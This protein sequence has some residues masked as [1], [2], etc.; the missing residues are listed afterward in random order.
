LVAYDGKAAIETV[1]NNEVSL[2]LLD[3]QLPDMSG[4]E[5]LRQLD[6]GGLSV[7]SILITAN[8]SEHVAAEAFRL[9]VEDYLSK[10]VEAE[11]LEEAINKA[12]NETHLRQAK[13]KLT[14]QLQEQLANK[15]V[16]ADIGKSIT[17]SLDINQVLRKIVEAAV[18]LTKAEEGFLALLDNTSGQLYLRAEKNL[19][20]E[21]S[22]TIKLP[23]SDE[24][25]SKVFN[26]GK[27]V[28]ISSPL[29][30][31]SGIKLVTGFLVQSLMHVPILSKGKPQGV[32]SV[33]NRTY[34]N[35]FNEKFE[36]LLISLAD[37]A[38]IAIENASLYHKAQQEI[39]ERKRVEETLRVS[40]ERYALAAQGASDGIWDWDL[41]NNQIY[42][43]PRW[44]AML[45][46]QDEDISQ[47]PTEW[48]SRVSK[49]DLEG[50]KLDISAHLNK[51]TSHFENE[52]RIVHKDGSTRWMLCRGLAVF[53]DE[54]LATRVAGSI[55]DITEWK[56]AE[57]KLLHDAFY[58]KLTGIPNRALFMD[59]LRL[60][61]ERAKRKDDYAYAVLFL[62]IDRFKDVN[63]IYGHLIGDKLLAEF[64][65]LLEQRMR[66]TDTVARFGGDEFVILLDD[67]TSANNATQIAEW[68]QSEL[69]TPFCLE[70]RDIYISIST[71]IVLS[72]LEYDNADDVLRDADI[73]MYDAKANG[74][75]RYEMFEPNMRIRVMDRLELE[76]DLR[77]A[78]D[79][80]E[81]D[82][83]YQMI[84]SLQTGKIVGFEALVRWNHPIRGQLPPNLFIPIA[85]ESGLIIS[86]DR[87]VMKE[88][89]L[90]IK[91]WQLESPSFKDLA[92]SV[93]LSGNHFNESDLIEFVQQ[94]LEE[95][96]LS[97]D[98]LKL[99]ITESTLLEK[100]DTTTNTL[101]KLQDLGVQIQ[102]DDFGTGYSS[103][104]YISNFPI[105]ALKIDNSFVRSMM[106]DSNNLQI[107]KAIISLS[108]RLGVG[109]IAEGVESQN[110]LNQLKDLGCEYGQGFYV[111]IPMN[112]KDVSTMLNETASI[113]KN[114]RLEKITKSLTPIE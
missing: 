26:S 46:F 3:L 9:G 105:D 67:I 35:P 18:D 42:Y 21:K 93:N 65:Q 76:N 97:P 112:G 57:Q 86:I 58:D 53:N 17:S 34:A 110:Q 83:H 15:A 20:Q 24:L 109:V 100:D 111:A 52:H 43:S 59:H 113:T 10:P 32:L 96:E 19:D 69:M 81:L 55:T 6:E 8:G 23:V 1:R 41:R 38:A 12:L 114:G 54:G 22:R 31:E 90:Q 103:L 70:D 62:D 92:I 40:E 50:L 89:C 71:G 82:I 45:G 33:V 99:E 14:I 7:P 29:D 25:I 44:K 95:T 84:V 49:E 68:I 88:A 74:K 27:P 16:L 91:K 48:F 101:A 11:Q 104:S 51:T 60:A 78:I 61:V 94:T 75:S 98:S 39:R 56:Y 13:E 63:D 47:D 30:E 87:W 107:I 4:L 106:E 2:M 79:N 73:A 5:I 36:A 77:R 28:R 85:E 72:D 37:Y 108:N 102:I 64:A 66:S 80:E